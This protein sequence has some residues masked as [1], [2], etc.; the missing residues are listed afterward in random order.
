MNFHETQVAAATEIV[1]KFMD[2]SNR[3]RYGLLYALCQSGK[4][5]TFHAVA[6]MLLDHGVIERV[7]LLCGSSEV[8]LRAQANEDAETYNP[9][10]ITAGKFNIIFH[11]DFK[12]HAINR[13]KSLIILDESHMD[14]DANQKLCEFAL[15]SGFDFW[16]TTPRMVEEDTYILSVSATPYSELS[17]IYHKKTP[18]KFVVELVPGP[19]YRGVD[20]YLHNDLVHPTYNVAK[21]WVR[22]KTMVL[23]K[24]NKWNLVRCTNAKG[25]ALQTAIV[26][27]AAAA[28]IR[29]LFYTEAAKDV[30]ITWKERKAGQPCLQGLDA[31]GKPV[32][33]APTQPTIIILKGKLRAGKVVPKEHVGFV[34]EDS[35]NPQTD[36]IVQG[37]L[38][39]MCGYAFGAE[40]PEIYIS[41]KLLEKAHGMIKA[42][43]IVRH[44]MMPVLMPKKGRNLAGVRDGSDPDAHSRH[45]CVPLHLKAASLLEFATETATP[46][47]DWMDTK[48]AAT[49]NKTDLAE[50]VREYIEAKALVESS[51]HYSVE[52]KSEIASGWADTHLRHQQASTMDGQ[53]EAF[54]DFKLA[55][56][57]G[58]C[59]I[60]RI[61]GDA[62]V[63]LILCHIPYG[64]LQKGDIIVY[65]NASYRGPGWLPKQDLRA[66][67]PET[68]G[69]EMFLMRLPE[70]VAAA[71]SAGTVMCLRNTIID[72]PQALRDQVRRIIQIEQEET[73]FDR[74]VIVRKIK[75]FLSHA[76]SWIPLNKAAYAY[77]SKDDNLLVTICNEIST[78][79]GVHVVPTLAKNAAND[80]IFHIASITW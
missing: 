27:G 71:A 70:N 3:Y 40:M 15:A 28:G 16:G 38:G 66:R 63:T 50:F 19:T 9:E 32:S 17:D 7:Y 46:L 26:R 24:G 51:P 65:F 79:L 52:Q 5:G 74:L 8:V 72:S 48:A 69:K 62:V 55:A 77:V 67:F 35:K 20:Y 78:E 4:T 59:P 23:S 12:K 58:F 1:S 36:T 61:G 34:W 57:E 31:T 49:T 80:S 56:E 73:A 21:E 10:A 30:A 53:K 75:G 13:N 68:T 39:R 2:A 43:A 22:F 37:L 29:V 64:T 54:M 25:S 76:N 45:P 47:A 41:G 60:H 42:N 18:N 44:T 33:V 14:Q 11:Q 6:K